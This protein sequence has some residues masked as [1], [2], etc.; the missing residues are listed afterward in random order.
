MEGVGGPRSILKV[1]QM[2]LADGFDIQDEGQKEK[3]GDS[4]VSNLTN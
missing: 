2:A 4:S 1:E 3:M